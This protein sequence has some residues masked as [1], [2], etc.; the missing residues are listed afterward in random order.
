VFQAPQGDLPLKVRLGEA[1]VRQADRTPVPTA[2]VVRIKDD[3]ELLEAA[4][5]TKAAHVRAAEVA[6]NAARR[7]LDLVRKVGGGVIAGADQATIESEL[8]SA[9]AQLEVRKAE[10]GEH[11]VKVKQAKRRLDEALGSRPAAGPANVREKR[12]LGDAT[13]AEVRRLRSTE[14]LRPADTDAERAAVAIVRLREELE[15]TRAIF[16]DLTAKRKVIDD[17]LKILS[18]QQDALKAQMKKVDADLQDLRKKYPNEGG[19]RRP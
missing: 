17:Q 1:L 11:A 14:K 8:E 3:L 7:K 9:E 4:G 19:P 2:D 5:H 18:Q 16:D 13:D 10:Y 12:P 15:K 6:V